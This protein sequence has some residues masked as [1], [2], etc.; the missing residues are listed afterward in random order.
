MIERLLTQVFADAD[1]A[2][3]AHLISESYAEHIALGDFYDAARE[4]VDA[5]IESAIGL[6]VPPPSPP[7]TPILE[8]L[9]T[10]YVD[11]AERREETCQDASVLQ[12]LYDELLHVYTTAIFK[13][14][15]MK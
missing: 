1:S 12:T 11:L 14:K 8:L 3:R 2:H 7:D 13:L 15:R 6:D 9:E 10:A 4:K 5:I